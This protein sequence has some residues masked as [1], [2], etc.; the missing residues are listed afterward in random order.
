MPALRPILRPRA[1]MAA[2]LAAVLLGAW[3]CAGVRP[4]LGPPEPTGM[5]I[6]QPPPGERFDYF[7]YVGN[8]DRRMQDRQARLERVRA[9]MATRCAEPRVV[10]LYAHEVGTWPDGTPHITY[11]VG[12]VCGPHEGEAK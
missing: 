9:V 12:V 5:F 2:L 3:G 7:V 1:P 11:T 8:G 6:Y 10:D 4:T